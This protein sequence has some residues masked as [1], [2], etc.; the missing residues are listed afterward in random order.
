MHGTGR[1]SVESVVCAT[2][3]STTSG[4]AAVLVSGDAVTLATAVASEVALAVT[5]RWKNFVYLH[6]ECRFKQFNTVEN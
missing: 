4:A 3:V 5:T 2:V 1:D 6:N